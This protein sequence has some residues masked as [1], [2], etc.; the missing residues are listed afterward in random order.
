MNNESKIVK[1]KL[2]VLSEITSKNKL[3]SLNYALDV[4]LAFESTRLRLIDLEKAIK[5]G[6]EYLKSLNF[7]IKK[8]KELL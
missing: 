7:L 8:T 1:R 3:Q 2:A 6:V 4:A 5:T